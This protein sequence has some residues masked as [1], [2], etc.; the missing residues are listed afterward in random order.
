M[1]F[2]PVPDTVGIWNAVR[3]QLLPSAKVIGKS[4]VMLV[5][6]LTA[7]VDPRGNKS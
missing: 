2:L 4:Q 7:A 3:P 1:G 6:K 5:F